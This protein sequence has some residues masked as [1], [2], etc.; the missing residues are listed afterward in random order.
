[1]PVYLTLDYLFDAH[2]PA[3]IASVISDNNGVHFVGEVINKV[4]TGELYFRVGYLLTIIPF[5][6]GRYLNLT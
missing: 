5:N 6:M 4:K 3:S 1:V 2:S